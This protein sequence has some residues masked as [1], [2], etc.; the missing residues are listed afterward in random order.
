[1]PIPADDQPSR[2]DGIDRW[3]GEVRSDEAARSRSR[4]GA[5]RS[6]GGE[7]ATFV[8]V[9]ADL[10]ERRETVVVTTAHGRRHRVQVRE[11]GPDAAVFVAGRGEWL[12]IRLDCVS[13]VRLLGGDAVHGEASM[14]TTASFGRL[15]ARAAE[16]GDRLRFWLGGELVSGEVVSISSE[17]AVLRLDSADVTYVNLAVVEEAQISVRS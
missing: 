16:P 17:V 14:T 7:D 11:V 3:L 9:L 6:H 4:V 15:V 5:L 1:M 2:G 12:V 8:G 10:V 13:A